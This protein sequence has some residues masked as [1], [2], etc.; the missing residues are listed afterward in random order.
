[1]NIFLKSSDH[2]DERAKLNRVEVLCCSL[3]EDEKWLQWMQK[4]FQ[5]IAGEDG[6]IDCQ[7]FKG[8]LKVKKV[9]HTVPLLRS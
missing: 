2:K 5:E 3:D 7:E 9:S 4:Q 8:A 6:E 1:M